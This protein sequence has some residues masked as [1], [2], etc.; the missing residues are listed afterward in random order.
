MYL[1]SGM[2]GQSSDH[3]TVGRTVSLLQPNERAY[4]AENGLYPGNWNGEAESGGRQARSRIK[5]E[6]MTMPGFDTPIRGFYT[7]LLALSNFM[8]RADR[9]DRLQWENTTL[10]AAK[11]DME[12]LRDH[13]NTLI[14]MAES[15]EVASQK[16]GLKEAIQPL[17][18]YHDLLDSLTMFMESDNPEPTD[19]PDDG[20]D[21]AF[22]E[23]NE[24]QAA[25]MSLLSK[26]DRPQILEYVAERDRCELPDRRIDG[27]GEPWAQVAS[28]E[29]VGELEL[30]EK[31]E[32]RNP[33]RKE[34]SITDRG[35][36]VCEAWE[37]LQETETVSQADDVY[38]E[39]DTR[40]VVRQLLL[41]H[42]STA[43]QE[44]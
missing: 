9:E 17:Y 44:V 24:R 23:R 13:L 11:Q 5:N 20:W 1:L 16:N 6:I 4:L 3:T 34:Y 40:E 15:D 29:L 36:A 43:F 27:K 10:P 7:D 28:R 19:I 33:R 26:S 25:L 22:E 18:Q 41:D 2:D 30:L 12:L 14:D 35:K 32:E 38:T 31:H 8:I 37:N 42:L 21:E 39:Q